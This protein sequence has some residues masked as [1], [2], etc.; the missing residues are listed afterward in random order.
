MYKNYCFTKI[1]VSLSF[2]PR[3]PQSQCLLDHSSSGGQLDH[4]AEGALP[5]ERFNADQQCEQH[6]ISQLPETD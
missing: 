5:G 2:E 6:F 3:T 1:N 4:S